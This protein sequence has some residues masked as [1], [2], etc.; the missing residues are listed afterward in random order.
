MEVFDEGLGFLEAC[1]S[2]LLYFCRMWKAGPGVLQI[3]FEL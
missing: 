3:L 2:S 1:E